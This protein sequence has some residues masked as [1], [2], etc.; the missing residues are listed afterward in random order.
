MSKALKQHYAEENGQNRKKRSLSSRVVSRWY[1]APEAILTEK[2]YD[3][4]L[5]IWS[6]GCILAETL[7]C[8]QL[9]VDAL[10]ASARK[11]RSDKYAG[12]FG[13]LSDKEARALTTQAVKERFYFEGGSCYPI[14]P[15]QAAKADETNVVSNDDQI[16]KINEDYG[17]VNELDTSFISNENIRDY[18]GKV[19][20]NN[21][22]QFERIFTNEFKAC[23]S[24]LVKLAL[25]MLEYNPFF[26]P[27]AKECLA[28]PVFEDIRVQALERDATR[29]IEILSDEV[30]PIDYTSGRVDGLERSPENSRL[31]IFF[32]KIEIL[33]EIQLLRGI[34]F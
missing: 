9:Q 25:E 14:S 3:F 13:G 18:Q 6:L 11:E 29:A 31:V 24:L 27:S 17:K 4:A 32:F 23:N 12:N 19:A 26:R 16:I 5:D 21:P 28:S 2:D 34:Q 20:S 7:R 10:I 1:R 30:L 33:K 8:S 22:K 15:V